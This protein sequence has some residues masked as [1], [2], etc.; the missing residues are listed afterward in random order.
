MQLVC[1]RTAPH[2]AQNSSL[3]QRMYGSS[4]VRAHMFVAGR[5]RIS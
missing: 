3:L 4:T 2:S 1:R 5:H